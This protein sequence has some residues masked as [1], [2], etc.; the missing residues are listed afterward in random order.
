MNA[1][2]G[3]TGKFL[4]YMYLIEN[5]PY[6]VCPLLHRNACF[7]LFPGHSLWKLYVSFHKQVCFLRGPTTQLL[8]CQPLPAAV[9]TSSWAPSLPPPSFHLGICKMGAKNVFCD[10]T[11]HHVSRPTVWDSKIPF[12]KEQRGYLLLEDPRSFF[13]FTYTV[14]GGLRQQLSCIM[15]Y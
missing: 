9:H 4:A 3:C 8:P 6:R 2:E 13:T 1:M 10:L 11:L 15:Q 7:S 14:P 12:C 5:I